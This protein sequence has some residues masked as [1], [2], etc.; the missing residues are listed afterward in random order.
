M[1]IV[2]IGVGEVGF[3]VAKALSIEDHD[4]TVIDIN[5]DKCR[6]ASEHLDVIVVHGNGASPKNLLQANIEGADYVLALTRVDEV[7]LIASQQAHLL[8][9][10]KIIARLRNQHYSTR[11]SII[12]PEKFGID[13]VIHPEK[14]ACQEIVRLVRHPYSTQVM[15]FEGGRLLML[16]FR[17]VSKSPI[18]NQTVRK[19]CA[20]HQN[21][22][23]GIIGVLREGETSIPWADFEFKTN[24]IAY[25]L[26]QKTDLEN[27]LYM[28]GRRKKHSNRIMIVGASKI[29]RSVAGELQDE[30]NVRILENRREKAGDVANELGN[31]MVIYGDGTDVELLKSENISEVDSFITVTNNEQ[32]NLLSSML[33]H[34]LGVRQTMI[35]ITTTEYM[36]IIQEIGI[37][38]VISK[39]LSTV[40]SIMREIRSDQN[41]MS[42]MSFDEID[43]E[44]ME[45]NPEIGSKVTLRPLEE[46]AFPKDSIVGVINHHGHLSIARGSSQ[47]TSEDTVLVFAKQSAIPKL[48][49][50]FNV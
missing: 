14:A 12:R 36:P 27:L 10:K 29:G 7:N 19:I 43:V 46:L 38:A 2:I 33:A 20:D 34:H 49:K 8:G 30:M 3:H 23:F 28:L 11:E 32:T 18:A 44:V 6:R 15:E 13:L 48:K 40:N 26:I 50:L 4:I 24:D 5:P 47:L 9:A 17:I 39:N 21:L 45:F 22:K 42:V 1:R 35:H 16:G 31:T 37:G 41:E 25:F